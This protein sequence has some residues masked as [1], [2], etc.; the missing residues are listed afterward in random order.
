MQ[1]TKEESLQEIT[2]MDLFDD[3]FGKKEDSSEKNPDLLDQVV[4]VF[5]ENIEKPM[6]EKVE[7]H[8]QDVTENITASLEAIKNDEEPPESVEVKHTEGM[9]DFDSLTKKWDGMI[10]EIIDKK[11]GAVK[12]CPNC[13][14]EIPSGM[15][16][17][18]VCGTKLPEL[19]AAQVVCSKCGTV[20]HALDLY[21]SKCGARLSLI[22]EE[23]EK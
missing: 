9:P 13:Q 19:T 16:Y 11:L 7:H 21:C 18:T 12:I 14:A 6:M 10:D 1:K 3:I 17:C 15:N 20:N 8:F 4:N 2:F 23:E 22:P 5:K